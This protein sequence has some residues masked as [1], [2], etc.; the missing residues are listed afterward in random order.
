MKKITSL[1]LILTLIC[2]FFLVVYAEEIYDSE[3]SID[4]KNQNGETDKFEC[5]DLIEIV[6]S[7][8][9]SISNIRD[10]VVHFTYNVDLMEYVKEIDFYDVKKHFG[11]ELKEPYIFEK[12]GAGV[13]NT[14]NIG[15]FTAAFVSENGI[16]FD[17][18][19]AVFK[20]YFRIKND[21][22]SGVCPLNIRWIKKGVYASYVA[23][24]SMENKNY[25]INFNDL[26]VNVIGKKLENPLTELPGGE[27]SS[28]TP[29]LYPSVENP[30][31]VNLNGKYIKLTTPYFVTFSK[32]VI[33]NSAL[34]NAGVI[35]SKKETDITISSKDAVLI[36][37]V[38]IGSDNCFGFLVYGNGIK[39]GNT[40]Y[41]RVYATYEDGEIV[42]G[43][44]IPIEIKEGN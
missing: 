34:K 39:A 10:S 28:F 38:N 18:N 6:I 3:W 26:Y 16:S 9:K 22:V 12:N 24:S 2:S 4:I 37:A 8:S 36:D 7:N 35:I 40:Y 44:V 33:R 42:Y 14:K 31:E 20:V 29:D 19:E 11:I 27:E 5:G 23:D 1:L 25:K 15:T 43:K 32:L 21:G 30:E 13:A 17:E 41:T